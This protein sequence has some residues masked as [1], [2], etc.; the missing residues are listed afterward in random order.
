MKLLSVNAD[1]GPAAAVLLG[2]DVVLAESVGAPGNMRELLTT[3]DRDGLRTLVARAEGSAARRLALAECSLAAPVP[4]A[5]KIICIGL[6]YRDHAEETGQEHP[7][8]TDVVR[9]VRRTRSCGSGADDRPAGSARRVRRLRGGARARD[10]PRGRETSRRVMRSA[11]I[12]GAMPFNDVSARDLQMQNPLWTSGKAIDTFAPM[13]A[14]AR[15][16]R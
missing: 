9:Q 13:R 16:A 14:G 12:A 1:T 15:D 7:A 4:D 10:R 2:E 6:N 5:E 8:G 3:L 11:Y